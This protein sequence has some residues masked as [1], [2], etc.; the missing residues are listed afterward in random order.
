MSDYVYSGQEARDQEKAR[1]TNERV[2]A[3][4][5]TKI[6]RPGDGPGLASRIKA[7][8]PA[9]GIPKS[10]DYPDSAAYMAAM[11]KYREDQNNDPGNVAQKK[12]LGSMK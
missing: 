12:V 2:K 1:D 10:S 11:R 7:Q 9:S 6:I 8:K 4:S 3:V 5:D